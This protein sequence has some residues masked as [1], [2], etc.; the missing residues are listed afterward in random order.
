MKRQEEE[1]ME[2]EK[3]WKRFKCGIG[4]SGRRKEGRRGGGGGGNGKEG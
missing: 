4:A 1:L 3:R 2:V